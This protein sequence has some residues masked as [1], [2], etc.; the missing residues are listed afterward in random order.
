MLKVKLLMRTL[1]EYRFDAPVMP[2][3]SQEAIRLLRKLTEPC[4]YTKGRRRPLYRKE[5]KEAEI[6][7]DFIEAILNTTVP[8][9][10]RRF[11]R[12]ELEARY[13]PGM[14]MIINVAK[15]WNKNA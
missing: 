3:E 4:R 9:R 13:N 8:C 1:F 10:I 15:E 6:V 7:L 11:L 2:P 5:R 14:A 12:T